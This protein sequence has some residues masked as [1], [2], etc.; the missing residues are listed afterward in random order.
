MSFMEQQIRGY[1]Q[2]YTTRI[3]LVLTDINRRFDVI[4][5]MLWVYLQLES[6]GVNTRGTLKR[7]QCATVVFKSAFSINL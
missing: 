4:D 1:Y 2:T 3:Q 5:I 6:D 7:T